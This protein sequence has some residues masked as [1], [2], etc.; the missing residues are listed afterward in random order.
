MPTREERFAVAAAPA[1]LWRF[2]RDFPA[3]CACIPGVEQLEVRDERRLRLKVRENVGVVPLV[4]D[5]QAEIESEEP[6]RR[7]RALARAEHLTMHIEV[8][9]AP[10]ASGTLLHTRFEVSGSGPLKP[11]VDRLFEKRA[12]ERSARFA[13]CLQEQF[14]TAPPAGP[15]APARALRWWQRLLR[16]FTRLS[17]PSS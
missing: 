10:D 1:E 13:A 14:A 12:A 9:L 2:L 8:E 7:L 3:L 11:V 15:A 16:W 6:G 4:V 17:R 5:L